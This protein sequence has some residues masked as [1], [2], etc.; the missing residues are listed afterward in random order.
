MEAV[1]LRSVVRASD[2]TWSPFRPGISICRLFG[3]GGPGPSA[4]LLKYEPGGQV[5][6]HRH[7][8]FEVIFMIAGSQTDE[9]CT[10]YAQDVKV[11]P[12]GTAHSV[13]SRNGCIALLLW[14]QPVSFV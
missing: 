3:D 6:L 8:G 1:G 9:D 14:Q 4:A 5:P 7:R 10:L 13:V 12:P 11:N 2:V